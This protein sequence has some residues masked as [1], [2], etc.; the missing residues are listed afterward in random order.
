MSRIFI[1]YRRGDTPGD[2]GR[3]AD[4]LYQ[5]F[6][7]ERVFLDIDAIAPGADFVRALQTSLQET[8][9]VLVVVGP[10]WTT[11]QADDQTRR[12]DDP[13]DFVRLEVATALARNIPVVPV[14]VQGAKMP[15]ASELP[16]DLEA[17]A[18]RQAFVVD[19]HEFHAD[20]NRLCDRLAPMLVDGD[21]RTNPLRR[22]WPAAVAVLM[23]AA[24]A[25]AYFSFRR[26]DTGD[27]EQTRI[28]VPAVTE[29][30]TILTGAAGNATGAAGNATGDSSGNATGDSSGIA[31]GDARGRRG[32][33]NGGRG[34]RDDRRERAEQLVAEAANLRRRQQ[35]ADALTVLAR[36]RDLAPALPLTRLAQEDTAM[37]WL[38][39]V[40]IE[41][42]N[43][44]FGGTIKPATAVIDAGLAIAKGNRRA[45]LLAHS[46]WAAFLLWRDGNRQLDPA[47]WYRESIAIDP[48]NPYANAMLAHW[49]LF[50][51]DDVPQAAALFATAYRSK[52]AANVVRQFQ[53]A[54]YGNSSTPQMDPHRI[55]LANAMRLDDQRL[56]AGEAQVLWRQYYSGLSSVR[57]Q[58]P[59]GQALLDA[60]PPDDYISTLHWSFDDYTAK[61]ESRQR[62]LRYYIALLHDKAG[63]RNQA[64][65]DLQALEQE[66][67]KAPGSMRDAIAA[68]LARLR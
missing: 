66:T 11:L 5:R 15:A 2:A 21:G 19:H 26:D 65:Q 51:G 32:D 30:A 8:A 47:E 67:A 54:A 34:A 25:L 39:N 61:D 42:D 17:L 62:M 6:G 43:G 22:W 9:V 27:S 41:G 57:D 13:K 38:R 64:V 33:A 14:L 55:Q 28:E 12:L 46:G 59:Q 44:T 10:K 58:R 1:S 7:A 20:A 48:V 63:R 3:L 18:T 23:L 56:S 35:Y 24:A 31:T 68:S 29:P 4:R 60:L 52:R 36:A 50:R 16:A 45:D 53:W 37:E 40:R 49:T